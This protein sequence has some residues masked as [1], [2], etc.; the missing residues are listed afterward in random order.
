[1]RRTSLYWPLRRRGSCSCLV[2]VPVSRQFCGV[3]PVE[4]VPYKEIDISNV[5]G[6]TQASFY[7]ERDGGVLV[8]CGS[9][10]GKGRAYS[11][12][13]EFHLFG[14][15]TKTYH[16]QMYDSNHRLC[17]L[18]SYK[19]APKLVNYYDSGARESILAF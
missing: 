9:H 3:I 5:D 18:E 1:M 14:D 19:E 13:Q 10:G 12:L 17:N 2:V 11:P 6:T 7:I 16:R 15:I 8:T 4:Q